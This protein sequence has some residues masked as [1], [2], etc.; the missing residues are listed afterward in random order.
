MILSLQ[1]DC[2]LCFLKP[3]YVRKHWPGILLK[4]VVF[5]SNMQGIYRLAHMENG[6]FSNGVASEG[7]ERNTADFSSLSEKKNLF[8]GKYKY[9]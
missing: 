6:E 7:G 5:S 2:V 4:L 9:M 3:L 8:S 1:Y